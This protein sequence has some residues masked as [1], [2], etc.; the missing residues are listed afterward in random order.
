M[1]ELYAA[2]KKIP[3]D[4]RLLELATPSQLRLELNSTQ[5]PGTLYQDKACRVYTYQELRGKT[6][7]FT[8]KTFLDIF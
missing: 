2:Y 5:T 6:I 3:G 4:T 7:K 8:D 1:I